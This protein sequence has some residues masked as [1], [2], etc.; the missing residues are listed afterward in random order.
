[1][2]MALGM[3]V[4]IGPGHIVLDGDPAPF[5]QKGGRARPPISAHFYCGQTAVCISIP[6]GREVG[7]SLGDIVLHGDAAPHQKRAQHSDF[8]PMSIVAKL[9]Y[10]CIRIPPFGMEVSLSLGNI[11]LDGDPALLP[12]KGHS[13]FPNFRPMSI[14]A[15]WLDGLRYHLVWR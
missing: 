1:M 4:G 14:V 3:E 15:K 11:V 12:L 7:L 2:K 10:V 8:Q 13:L 5:L 9:L 6:P